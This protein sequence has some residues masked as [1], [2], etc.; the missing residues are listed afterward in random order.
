MEP[1]TQEHKRSHIRTSKGSLIAHK[2]HRSV[3]ERG[4]IVL[5]LVAVE[6]CKANL[7]HGRL[8]G[9]RRVNKFKRRL[10]ATINRRYTIRKRREVL[11]HDA[12]DSINDCTRDPCD[13]EGSIALIYEAANNRDR[14]ADYEFVCGAG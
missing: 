2:G 12:G 3:V 9:C 4:C 13:I 14:L 5:A 7:C 8:W 6:D 10:G 11:Q 1:R